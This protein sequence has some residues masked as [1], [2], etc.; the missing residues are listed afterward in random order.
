MT[1]I[2]RAALFAI[3]FFILSA[4]G[5]QAP[6]QNQSTATH[7]PDPCSSQNLPE[8]VQGI[9]DLMSEFYEASQD[10]SKISREQLPSVISNL[11]RIR[12]RAEDLQIP[13]CLTTLKSHQLNHM[14][15]TI[16]ALLRFIGGE[17]QAV[18]Q[19]G[20]QAAQEEHDLYSLEMVRLLGITLAPAAGTPAAGGTAAAPAT[21]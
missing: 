18:L 5:G 7:N 14:N 2:F 11:Q 3:F 20:M 10:A 21:P 4:C 13:A 1:R 6:V 19:S 17:E 15:L 8:T 12:R 16:Q 9:D